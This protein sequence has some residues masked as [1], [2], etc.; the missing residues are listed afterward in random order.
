MSWTNCWSETLLI[1]FW[2]SL[3]A[4][5]ISSSRILYRSC[6]I[7]LMLVTPGPSSLS[8]AGEDGFGLLGLAVSFF[9]IL[10]VK[11]GAEGGVGELGGL[12]LVFGAALVRDRV[13]RM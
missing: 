3:M 9:P 5:V 10:M 12:S 4:G 2:V 1:S 8:T 7:W 11:G 6:I 13:S